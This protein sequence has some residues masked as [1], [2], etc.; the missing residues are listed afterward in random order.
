MS[1]V[2]YS[3]VCKKYGFK[4]IILSLLA[5]VG[6]KYISIGNCCFIHKNARIEAV[7]FYENITYMPNFIMEDGVFIQQ[8]FH[9]TCTNLIKIGR[10]ISITA[11]VGIYD[12]V[13]SYENVDIN[14]RNQSY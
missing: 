10:G 2:R 13:H 11:N 4:T 3:V 8:K 9:C 1:Y 14:P 12:I 6:T 5:I 7:S